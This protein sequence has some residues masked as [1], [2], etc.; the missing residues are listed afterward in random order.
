MRLKLS[1][2]SFA[3]VGVGVELGNEAR[4]KLTILAKF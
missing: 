1:N 4:Y 3:G 2:P